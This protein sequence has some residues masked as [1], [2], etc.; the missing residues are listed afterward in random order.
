MNLSGKVTKP[1]TVDETLGTR[2]AK[3]GGFDRTLTYK[4]NTSYL[5]DLDTDLMSLSFKT[6]KHHGT[7]Q[8]VKEES[9]FCLLKLRQFS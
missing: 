1:M 2:E 6:Q 4:K 3:T 5:G 7:N 9:G 8:N